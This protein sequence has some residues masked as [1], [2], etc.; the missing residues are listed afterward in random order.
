MLS[1]TADVAQSKGMT[2][3]QLKDTSH[4]V[5]LTKDPKAAEH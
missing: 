4:S 1:T 3:M 5:V 2:K